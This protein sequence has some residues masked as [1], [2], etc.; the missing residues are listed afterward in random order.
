MGCPLTA[1]FLATV[2]MEI[3]SLRSK[4]RTSLLPIALSV[5]AIVAGLLLFSKTKSEVARIWIFL[6]PVYCVVAGGALARLTRWRIA[7][8]I[9]LVL[10]FVI[11]LLMKHAH[12]FF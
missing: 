4:E 6:M 7:A 9:V 10:Q 12:D 2:V 11:V 8:A 3:G 5:L 1:V